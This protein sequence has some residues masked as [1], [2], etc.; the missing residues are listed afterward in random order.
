MDYYEQLR[1]NQ[2]HLFATDLLETI[3]T[4]MQVKQKSKQ[5]Q[6]QQ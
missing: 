4:K 5:L 3:A 1:D 2:K 6:A